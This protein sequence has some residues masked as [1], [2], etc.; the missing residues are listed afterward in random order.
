[1]PL[2]TQ[3]SPTLGRYVEAEL[4]LLGA[5]PVRVCFTGRGIG[6]GV[7]CDNDQQEQDGGPWHFGAKFGQFADKVQ[8]HRQITIDEAALSRLT[9]GRRRETAQSKS[10]IVRAMHPR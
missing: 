10:G 1:M 8:H 3:P 7:R 2:L 9:P 5:H 6:H 4:A